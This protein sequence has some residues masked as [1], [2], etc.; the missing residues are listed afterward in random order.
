M[1]K[2]R[3]EVSQYIDFEHVMQAD[4]FLFI[5][6][7]LHSTDDYFD[8]W[9]PVTTLYATDRGAPFEVFARSQSS[10]Y[11]K[12]MKVALGIED[13]APLVELCDKFSRRESHTPPGILGALN[14]PALPQ[15]KQLQ[16]NLEEL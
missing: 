3:A 5:Y 9:F 13:K 6:S 11:F 7:F 15:S 14:L 1:L 8:N 16:R 2:Q 12:K 4:F 10:S